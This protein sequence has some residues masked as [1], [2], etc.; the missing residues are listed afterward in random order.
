MPELLPV[1]RATVIPEKNNMK[2]KE[3]NGK[4]NG[5]AKAKEPVTSAEEEE[6]GEMIKVKKVALKR[7][8]SVKAAAPKRGHDSPSR[9]STSKA[10]ATPNAE[11]STSKQQCLGKNKG[12]TA[13]IASA[14]AKPQSKAKKVLFQ[15]TSPLQQPPSRLHRL[16][17]TPPPRPLKSSMMSSCLT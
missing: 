15:W 2:R 4:K 7:A 13:A 10:K 16:G 14:T 5:K 3:K 9:A 11:G 8:E 12:T 1:A 17:A 6:E